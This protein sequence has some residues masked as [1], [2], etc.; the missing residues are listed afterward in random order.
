MSEN[1]P[2]FLKNEPIGEDQFEGKSQE[3]MA[4]IISNSLENSGHGIIGIDGSWGSGKSNL[5]RI[6][7]KNLAVKKYN[8]FIYDVWG[9]QEDEQRRTILEEITEYINLNKLVDNEKWVSKLKELLAKNRETTTKR[10]PILSLGVILSIL[11][12]LLLPLLKVLGDEIESNFRYFVYALP[13]LILLAAYLYYFFKYF[14]KTGN[15]Y[16]IAWNKLFEF[17]SKDKIEETTFVTIN[18]DEPSVKKFRDWI[19]EI[20]KDLKDKKIVVVFDNF[21][22]LPKQ[23]ILGLWSSIHIFFAEHKYENIKVIIPFDRDHIKNAFG[24]LN[25]STKAKINNTEKTDR[26]EEFGDYAEDYI[27][28]TFDIVYRVAP[29]IMTNWKS[30]FEIKWTECFGTEYDNDEFRRT[31]QV[32]EILNKKITPREIIVLINEIATLKQIHDNKIPAQYLALFVINKDVILKN[33]VLEIS[34]PS[35]ING[36]EFIY[37]NDSN[38]PKY[39]T[40][41]VYQ[42]DPEKSLEIVFEQRLND[43][44]IKKDEEELNVIADSDIFTPIL[45]TVYPKISDEFLPNTIETLNAVNSDKFTS[46]LRKDIVWNDLIKRASKLGVPDHNIANYQKIIISKISDIN[47]QKE[48]IKSIVKQLSYDEKWVSVN[49]AKNIDELQLYLNEN[50]IAIDCFE[51]LDYQEIDNIDDFALLLKTKEENY[52]DYKLD[53]DVDELDEKLESVAVEDLIKIDYLQFLN[54]D[55]YKLKKFNKKLYS[56]FKN[57]FTDNKLLPEILRLLKEYDE[58][59]NTKDLSDANLYSRFTTVTEKDQLYYDFLAIRLSRDLS[60]SGHQSYFS[61]A[62]SKIDND[63]V[64]KVAKEI[65]YY[66]DFDDLLLKHEIFNG[67]PLYKEIVKK[68][69]N[70]NESK[71][72]NYKLSL[73]DVLPSIELIAEN[74]EIELENLI[75]KLNSWLPT[76][77]N[78]TSIENLSNKFFTKAVEIQNRLTIKCVELK[79]EYFDALTKED[80]LEIFSDLTSEDYQILQTIN[81]NNWSSNAHEAFKEDLVK[82]TGNITSEEID[83]QENFSKLIQSMQTKNHKFKNTFEDVRDEFIKNSNITNDSFYF[84]GDWIFKYANLKVESA[85]RTIF[86]TDFLDDEH[87][88]AILNNNVK[89]LK[90]ILEFSGDEAQ[91]FKNAIIEKSKDKDDVK[92]LGEQLGIIKKTKSK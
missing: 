64:V 10:K 82:R 68:L 39:I 22:R 29:P 52:E 8:F 27:N 65:L 88:I 16:L 5:V 11:S 92:L 23:K 37:S 91:D 61:T 25:H 74:T 81:Y 44:L 36:L 46:K 55:E 78:I 1:Y 43:A 48:Y 2:K 90:T 45:E 80:W 58:V 13:L 3:A 9:H 50:N 49:Y 20:D 75:N 87:S 14:N 66:I 6:V 89:T 73:K 12:L 62:L 57:N 54:R 85:V 86:K 35:F 51:L 7:E 34:K 21:D 76:D 84:Y 79:T 60:I 17:Y 72:G 70:D 63:Y 40:A 28:K 19:L 59:I 30:F 53:V 32:Y 56:D 24:D 69:V 26:K 83:N 67:I 42:L 15:I 31:T 38:L 18:E 47:E 41:I 33:P 77:L 71:F 4:K